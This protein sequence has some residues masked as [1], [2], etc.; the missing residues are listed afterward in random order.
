MFARGTPIKLMALAINGLECFM[1][2]G[3][4]LLVVGM[5]LGGKGIA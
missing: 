4:A 1:I 3:S 2:A 5:L